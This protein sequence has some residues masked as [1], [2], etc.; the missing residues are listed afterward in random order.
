MIPVFILIILR[1]F[2][3]LVPQEFLVLPGII[4]IYDIGIMFCFLY[5]AGSIL[6]NSNRYKFFLNSFSYLLLAFFTIIVFSPLVSFINFKQPYIE[7]FRAIRGSFFYVYFFVLLAGINTQTKLLNYIRYLKILAVILTLITVAQYFFGLNI[8]HPNNSLDI[9]RL[10]MSRMLNPGLDIVTLMFFILLGGLICNN[11]FF[12]IFDKSLLVLFSLQIVFSLT[13]SVVFGCIFSTIIALV[14][15]REY[16]NAFKICFAGVMVSSMYLFIKLSM[17]IHSDFGIGILSDLFHLTFDEI[18]KVKG[19]VALRVTQAE[20]YLKFGYENWFFGS[21]YISPIGRVAIKLKYP[22]ER[23][24]LGYI[25]MFSQ[26]GLVGLIW[27]TS[28]TIVFF[29]KGFRMLWSGINGVYRGIALGLVANFIFMMISF[30][31][32]PHFIDPN[33]ISVVAINLALLQLLYMPSIQE[34]SGNQ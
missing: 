32:L 27:L 15:S 2:F 25:I 9:G 34:K 19:N 33:R 26:Y 6:V 29:K 5:L 3:L 24:D 31:T 17:G 16:K 4:R 1:E 13:R 23:Q 21:G 30:I 8:F 14:I 22:F 20:T 11:K 28:L 7:G 10:G 12:S 18:T